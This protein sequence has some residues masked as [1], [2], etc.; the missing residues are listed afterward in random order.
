MKEKYKDLKACYYY[1]QDK[2]KLSAQGM[3]PVE[4][5]VYQGKE[6]FSCVASHLTPFTA[7]TVEIKDEESNQTKGNEGGMSVGTILLIV[8]G[9]ILLLVL[10]VVVIIMV[11][12][13]V[14]KG[15]SES[16]DGAFKK[17]EGL[18]SMS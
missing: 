6:Y 2:K 18:V 9:I 10:L 1:D 13:K 14:G 3:T 11:R 12:K 7:G 5:F 17:D 15:D 4:K 8:L 16:I